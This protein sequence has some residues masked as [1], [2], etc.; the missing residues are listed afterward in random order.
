MKIQ[1]ARIEAFLAKPDAAARAVLLYGPDAGLVRERADKLARGVRLFF[2]H[3]RDCA[4]ASLLRDD[5]G[6]Y[7]TGSEQSVLDAAALA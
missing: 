7:G 5:K 2:T 4:L 3:D 6:R 1:P